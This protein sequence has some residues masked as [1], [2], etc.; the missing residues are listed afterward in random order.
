VRPRPP[1]GWLSLLRQGLT[2]GVDY[3]THSLTALLAVAETVEDSVYEAG[4]LH[5]TADGIAFALD[6]PPLRVGAFA[7]LQLLVDGVAVPAE[8]IRFR[9]GEGRP[10]RSAA[11]V[12]PGWPLEWGPGDRT[13]FDVRVPVPDPKAR[14]CVRVE[15]R[16]YAIPPLVWCEVRAVPATGEAPG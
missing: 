1:T 11:T 6:N 16:T 2:L 13:E 10:W 15:L 9:P 12:T 3:G 4:S 14:V 5:R 7:E 8:R